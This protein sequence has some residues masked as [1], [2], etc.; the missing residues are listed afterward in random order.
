MDCALCGEP[1][2]KK[3]KYSKGNNYPNPLIDTGFYQFQVNGELLKVHKNCQVIRSLI[4]Q[5]L[6]KKVNKCK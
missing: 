6:I 3:R 2:K 4:E 5:E 1:L